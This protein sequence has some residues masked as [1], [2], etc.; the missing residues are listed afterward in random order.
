VPRIIK[1]II[2]VDKYR[3]EEILS[4]EN[5]EQDGDGYEY[6]E[7]D[8]SSGESSDRYDGSDRQRL[9]WRG[10]HD[11]GKNSQLISEVARLLE[12]SE[13]TS[14]D[15]KRYVPE[16]NAEFEEVRLSTVDKRA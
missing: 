12:A 1:K 4:R 11:R 16:A 14:T 7:D 10:H 13:E 9:T 2:V 6:F 5:D 3:L 8:I 15:D